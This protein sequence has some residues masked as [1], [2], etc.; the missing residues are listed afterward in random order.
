M[1][2]D[3][4]ALNVLSNFTVNVKF[5]EVGSELNVYIMLKPIRVIE[6]I[7]VYITVA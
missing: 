1:G 2:G 6:R 3:I 4:E 7:N 5:D